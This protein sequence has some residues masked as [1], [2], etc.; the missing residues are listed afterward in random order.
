MA[1]P[2]SSAKILVALKSALAEFETDLMSARQVSAKAH[3]AE[4]GFYHGGVRPIGWMASTVRETDEHGRSGFRLIPHP[5]EYPAVQDAVT[6]A[7][8]GHGLKSI[9]HHWAEVHGIT[10]AGGQ[11]VQVSMLWRV[12]H[13]PH[14][15]GYRQY[16]VPP[17]R[18]E[19]TV[20]AWT[21]HLPT[22]P[23]V[24]MA[25]PSGPTNPFAIWPPSC[26]YNGC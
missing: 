5:V 18:S 17:W 26:N 4:A 25:N 11:P 21:T 1:T 22:S 15:L 23:K 8:A 13:S 12:L 16:R 2:D 6:M 7:L 3:A 9:S 20:P 24:L 10:T 19:A 14:L